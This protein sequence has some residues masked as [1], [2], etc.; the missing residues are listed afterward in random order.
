[1]PAINKLSINEQQQPS[2]I[3]KNL[4]Q[5]DIELHSLSLRGLRIEE[6]ALD[7][8]RSSNVGSLSESLLSALSGL[9]NRTGTLTEAEVFAQSPAA[10]SSFNSQSLVLNQM[11]TNSSNSKLKR[12]EFAT[13][14]EEEEEDKDD[15]RGGKQETMEEEL[16]F[17][18]GD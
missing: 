15:E 18:L 4:S 5:D 9:R 10:S 2:N 7:D 11:D 16:Q 1:M 14:M 8:K 17:E 3:R 13:L 12:K 6:D